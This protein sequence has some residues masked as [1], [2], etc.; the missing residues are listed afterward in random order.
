M[1]A[2]LTVPAKPPA[3]RPQAAGAA[4]QLQSPSLDWPST[5]PW[6]AYGKMVMA[7]LGIVTLLFGFISISGAVVATG[8]VAVESNT[9]TVQHLEG[10]IIQKIN[11]KNGDLVKA[12]DV[13][14]KLDDTQL[15]ANLGVSRGRTLDALT[16]QLRLEAERDSK[17]TFT[18][19]QS[20]IAGHNDP[21]LLRMFEAQHALFVARRTGKTGEQSVLKQ[22]V[23]QLRNDLGGMQQQLESRQREF[24]FVARELKGVLPLYEK[25]FIN[26]ARI[27]PLQRDNARLSGEVGRLSMEVEKAKSAMTEASLKLAQSDKEFQS[28]VADDLRKAL[29]A[30]NEANETLAGI[31]DKLARAEIRAPR[32]GRINGMSATTEGGV[33]AAGSPVLQVVPE[34]EKLIIEAKIQPQD[35]DKVRGGLNAVVKFP[36]FNAKSTPR[37]EGIVTTVSPSTLKDQDQQNKPYY[38]IQVELPAEELAKLGREHKLIPG[39]PAE[40]YI[41]TNP[42]SILSYV[43]KP[44]ADLFSHLGRDG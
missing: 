22:R 10:G 38:Q 14:I 44:I 11:V 35:V 30:F 36:A 25:G 27:S 7:A 12:G 15:R 43:V 3:L 1:S 21:Q 41:E 40:V 13:L 26:Q 6:I 33:I 32:S 34:D 23:E 42:R 4:L 20:L 2:A 29:G 19:P 17:P 16:Q 37:L 8:T 18:L 39:M 31:E 24:E 9:K 5:E 28:Q